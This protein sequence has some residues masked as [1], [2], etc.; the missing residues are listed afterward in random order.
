MADGPAVAPGPV[1]RL[2][3][4]FAP[5]GPELIGD[6]RVE[7]MAL[8]RSR[9]LPRVEPGGTASGFWFE[10]LDGDE[11]VLYRRSISS[12]VHHEQFDEDG[13]ITRRTRSG[14]HSAELEVLVPDLPGATEVRFV[15]SYDDDGRRLDA[16]QVM[17]AVR[18][19]DSPG[20]SRKG[21]ERG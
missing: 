11:K 3:I 4:R 15:S 6:F 1:R 18:M 9:S 19:P 2:L 5:A 13:T 14:E 12:P 17:G 8:P 21:Y 20:A 7:K 10:L 16:A